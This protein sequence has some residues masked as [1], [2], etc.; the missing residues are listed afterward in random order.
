MIGKDFADKKF[1]LRTTDKLFAKMAREAS[2]KNVSV[3]VL[4]NQVF[5]DRYKQIKEGLT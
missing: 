3:N 4:I 5:S 1:N 2:G